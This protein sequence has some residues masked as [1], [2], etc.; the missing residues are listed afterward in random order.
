MESN[1]VFCEIYQKMSQKL[2]KRIS[3]NCNYKS[4]QWPMYKKSFFAD[5]DTAGEEE[6]Y[7]WQIKFQTKDWETDIWMMSE[8]EFEYY[9]PYH[10][11][12]IKTYFE[13]ANLFEEE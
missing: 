1:S 7:I 5:H 4:Y 11:S 10:A 2:I 3:K 9:W 6:W 12:F 13:G 8:L